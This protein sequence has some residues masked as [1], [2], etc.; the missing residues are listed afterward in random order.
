MTWRNQLKIREALP[1]DPATIAMIVSK[2]NKDVAVKFGLNAENC[3]NHP[4]LCTE[5]WIEADLARGD[6]LLH[7]RRKRLAHRLRRIRK[8][9]R[10]TRVPES[11]VGPSSAPQQRRRHPSC[12]AHRPACTHC[13]HSNH[14]YRGDWRAH[15]AANASTASKTAKP[16]VSPTCPSP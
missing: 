13:S 7:P 10:R 4:S 6:D 2:S 14:Q 9:E 12:S 11:P 16:G 1:E 15:R 3:S 8:P 5:R